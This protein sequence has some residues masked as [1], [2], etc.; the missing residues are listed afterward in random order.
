MGTCY[1]FF[2]YQN[3]E[4]YELGKNFHFFDL[5]LSVLMIDEYAFKYVLLKELSEISEFRLDYAM[6]IVNDIWEFSKA[7]NPKNLMVIHEEE[8]YDYVCFH[9]CKLVGSRYENPEIEATNQR[10]KEYY[11]NKVKKLDD[12]EFSD[13]ALYLNDLLRSRNKNPRI[14]SK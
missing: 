8:M 3:N 11:E 6:E 1:Y 4:A 12:K 13:Y 7:R 2:D 10:W 9:K 14:I 5:D